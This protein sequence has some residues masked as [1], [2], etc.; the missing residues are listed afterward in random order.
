MFCPICGAKLNE[1]A[2]FC[3]ACGHVIGSE[4][5]PSQQAEVQQPEANPVSIPAPP[6][7]KKKKT[8]G[9]VLAIV[10]PLVLIGGGVLLFWEN[11]MGFALRTFSSPETYYEYVQEKSLEKSVRQFGEI[12]SDYLGTD[13]EAEDLAF[14]A[15]Y[16]V[17]IDEDLLESVVSLLDENGMGELI[18]WLDGL[19]I[20]QDADYDAEKEQNQIRLTAA[21][22]K[23]TVA[24]VKGILDNKAKMMYLALPGLSDQ[25]LALSYKDLGIDPP[26]PDE[27]PTEEE[28]CEVLTRYGTIIQTNLP[29]NS[30]SSEKGTYSSKEGEISCQ[31]IRYTVTEESLYNTLRAVCDAME[32]DETL[33]KIWEDFCDA[34]DAGASAPNYDELIDE[35]D[36]WLDDVRNEM[37]DDDLL[38]ITQYVSGSNEILGMKLEAEEETFTFSYFANKNVMEYSLETEEMTFA[39]NGAVEKKEMALEGELTIEDKTVAV[40]SGTLGENKTELLISLGDDMKKM[41]KEEMTGEAAAFIPYLDLTWRFAAETEDKKSTASVE[42]LLSGK[43]ALGVRVEVLERKLGEIEIPSEG[44]CVDDPDEWAE[45]I[46]LETLMEN[47]EKSGLSLGQI[48]SQNREQEIIRENVVSDSGVAFR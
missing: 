40:L 10:I 5:T 33:E 29:G 13:K 27:L 25:A 32:E 4:Q 30:I 11:V 44:R 21:T 41:L 23:G 31:V 14:T 24:T 12:Y 34:A 9:I 47:L 26:D 20:S 38:Q 6:A 19:T 36:S 1:E 46:D 18:P 35:F 22:G 37:G 16:D 8:L 39:I 43:T 17:E 7:P 42:L 45:T 2:K 3:S 28:I 48:G 15:Q